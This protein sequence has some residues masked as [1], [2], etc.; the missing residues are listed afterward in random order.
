[1]IVRIAPNLKTS[2]KYERSSWSRF[3]LSVSNDASHN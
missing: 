3:C 1:M 2:M